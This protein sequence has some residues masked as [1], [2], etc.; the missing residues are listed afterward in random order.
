MEIGEKNR[1]RLKTGMHV[2]KHNG[3]SGKQLS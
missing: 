2:P 1:Y 3:K